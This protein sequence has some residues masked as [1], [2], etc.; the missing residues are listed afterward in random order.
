MR[1]ENTLLS[2]EEREGG[3]I[4]GIAISEPPHPRA[5]DPIFMDSP[6]SG[7][8]EG[9]VLGLGGYIHEPQGNVQYVEHVWMEFQNNAGV[10]DGSCGSPI[11]NV[12]GQ[13]LGFFRYAKRDENLYYGV[14]ADQLLPLGYTVFHE[15]YTF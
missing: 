9:V 15:Q 2:S 11:L 10:V 14:A 12:D 1:Y 5:H 7:I 13:I 6:F 8:C 4:A 3:H